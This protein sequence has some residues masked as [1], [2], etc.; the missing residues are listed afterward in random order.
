[1]FNG[2]LESCFMSDN[3]KVPVLATGA[4]GIVLASVGAG[5]VRGTGAVL[6]VIGTALFAIAMQDMRRQPDD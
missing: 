5:M 6:M 2:L 4:I 3:G 1:M